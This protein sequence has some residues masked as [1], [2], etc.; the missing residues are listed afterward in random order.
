MEQLSVLQVEKQASEESLA[1]QLALTKENLMT[2]T[3]NYELVKKELTAA[4]DKLCE[5]LSRVH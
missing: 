5:L 4:N 3:T 2:V 1:S